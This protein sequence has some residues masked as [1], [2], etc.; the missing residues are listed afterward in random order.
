MESIPLKAII[1]NIKQ[2]HEDIFIKEVLGEVFI[3]RPLTKYE[4]FELIIN[5]NGEMSE[6]I[7]AE[8]ICSLCVLYPEDY[9]FSDPISAGIPETLFEEIKQYSG[10]TNH[11]MIKGIAAEYRELNQ[12]DFDHQMENIIMM[13]FPSIRLEEMRNWSIYKLVDYFARAEW[14]I[15]NMMPLLQ[16]PNKE[17]E[18]QQP[19]QRPGHF[20]SMGSNFSKNV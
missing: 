5:N 1:Y 19:E 11:E 15:E 7:L 2:Q 12:T 9:D 14:V 13:A 6:D 4:F 3:F 18:G 20:H 8:E 10:F 16:M 17:Q